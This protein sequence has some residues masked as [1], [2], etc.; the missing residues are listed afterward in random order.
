VNCGNVPSV[1]DVDL[2]TGQS[3]PTSAQSERVLRLDARRFALLSGSYDVISGIQP[4]LTDR[5]TGVY[6]QVSR[7]VM[8]GP[9]DVRI[10]DA[11]VLA[12]DRLLSFGGGLNGAPSDD[13]SAID[14]RSWTTTRLGP[15][16]A[17]RSGAAAI[18]LRDGRVLIVGGARQSPDRSIPLPPGAELFDPSLAP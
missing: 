10:A 6:D 12:G 9:A 3:L 15:M 11:T 13:A 8:P 2:V 18:G 14:I 7:V 17:S 4:T 5:I 16:L 1:V